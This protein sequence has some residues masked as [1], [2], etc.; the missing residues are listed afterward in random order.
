MSRP[1][2]G[3]DSRPQVTLYTAERHARLSLRRFYRLSMVDLAPARRRCK[4]TA[5]RAQDAFFGAF[6]GGSGSSRHGG[7]PHSIRGAQRV[8]HPVTDAGAFLQRR[9]EDHR[10]RSHG[11]SGEGAPAPASGR[12]RSFRQARSIR[13]PGLGNAPG[14]SHQPGRVSDDSGV[15]RREGMDSRGRRRL[16][17]IRRYGR[18]R[19]GGHQVEIPGGNR[20]PRISRSMRSPLFGLSSFPRAR[21]AVC[22]RCSAN[23]RTIY[24]VAVALLLTTA[25]PG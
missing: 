5:G 21:G 25:R 17:N 6:G 12:R 13:N 22:N 3:R 8:T 18:G 16:R 7:P 11:D 15:P 24:K 9:G 10:K 4:L 23:T 1:A 14:G 20:R 19:R 2:G